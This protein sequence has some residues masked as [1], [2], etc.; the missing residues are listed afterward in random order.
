MAGFGLIVPEKGHKSGVIDDGVFTK[1]Q[2][3][4]AAF[5]Y[6]RGRGFP[7]HKLPLYIIMQHVNQLAQT[8]SDSL[9]HSSVG[10][11]AADTYHPHRFHG[12]RAD[13]KQSPVKWWDD[14]KW[15][16]GCLA[17][18][19]KLHDGKIQDYPAGVSWYHN[20]R[21][22]FNFRPG[23]AL[24]LYRKYCPPG[25]VILDTSTGFGGRLL[26]FFAS[27]CG[28]YIG[29]DPAK[30]VYEGNLRM[31]ADFGMSDKVELYCQPAEEVDHKLLAERCDFAFTS[32]PY[33][34]L[35]Q[36]A[37]D[38]TQCWKRFPSADGWRVGFLLPMM[39][40]Q[41]AALK[42]GS[43]AAVN[44]ADAKIDGEKIPLVDWTVE[45]AVAAGFRHVDTLFFVLQAR[46]T[47]RKAQD[48]GKVRREPVLIF[49]KEIG[50]G[51][52]S[53]ASTKQVQ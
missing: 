23:F 12:V 50:D 28:R 4:E 37:G 40:L 41:Y 22:C 29:I 7:Y 16:R 42:N 24:Y 17:E 43:V 19:Y 44:I 36:Y 20:C 13:K 39:R 2:I 1:E 49:R 15:L 51:A 3:L 38:D 53:E 18:T 8:P 35:E 14:D 9:M 10:Y 47:S 52:V 5:Q 46:L 34:A 32:P 27:Q 30:E 25:G 48:F 26:G 33:F 11:R 6:H 21:P 45:A 31:A